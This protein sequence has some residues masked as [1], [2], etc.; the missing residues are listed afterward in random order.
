MKF[1]CEQ[2]FSRLELFGFGFMVFYWGD[3][4]YLFGFALYAITCAITVLVQRSRGGK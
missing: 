3:A 4:Q 2:Y 1:L